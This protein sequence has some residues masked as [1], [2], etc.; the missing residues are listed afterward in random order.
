[1]A[2]HESSFAAKSHFRHFT[3]YCYTRVGVRRTYLAM[4]FFITIDQ[5][6]F[7]FPEFLQVHFDGKRRDN[8]ATRKKRECMSVA[9]PGPG[10]DKEKFLGDKATEE[11]T[12]VSV[13]AIVAEFLRAWG[14][15]PKQIA[16]T[17]DTCSVNTGKEWGKNHYSF[18]LDFFFL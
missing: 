15:D 1:M 7:K 18:G 3:A 9:V 8:P 11:G 12:G 16:I 10:M 6:T 5:N 17:Y 4:N 2:T 13:G 14:L